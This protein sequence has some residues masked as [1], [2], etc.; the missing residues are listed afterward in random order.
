MTPSAGDGLVLRIIPHGESD[1]LVTWYSA[2]SGR[3]T[4]IAK[5]AQKSKKRFSNKLE[6]FSLLHVYYRSPRSQ[7]GLHF[8]VDA[9]LVQANLNL[10]QHY[11]KY[12]A[13]SSI[14]ELTIRFTRE[15]DPDPRIY[16]LLVWA[17]TEINR[18]KRFLKF[19]LFFHLQLLHLVGYMPNLSTCQS[20]DKTLAATSTVCLPQQGAG[21]AFLRCHECQPVQPARIP[22][23]ERTLSLQ[24]MKMLLFA[25]RSDLAT[26][27]KLQPAQRCIQEGMDLLHL[28]SQHLLQTDLYTWRI[29]R[30]Y[31]PGQ[32]RSS[33]SL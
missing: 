3:I 32:S 1:K 25:G 7:S 21:G 24:T 15:L 6:H 28:Y 10:R 4:A 9:D 11:L 8:L 20:C 33:P 26:L 22:G 17:L 5:G 27:R 18:S 13:A 29:L 30:R 23:R 12:L 31:L 14:T 16:T 2:Q 19:P